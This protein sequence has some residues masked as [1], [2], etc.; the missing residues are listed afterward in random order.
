MRSFAFFLCLFVL[1]SGL[2]AQ[3]RPSTAA[4]NVQVIEKPFH[5]PGL[6]RE[7]Q[8][9]LYLP[10]GYAD[11]NKSYPVLYMHDG[12]NLFDKATAYI[13]EWGVDEVLNELYEEKGFELI[14][15]GIDNGM[16]D[17]I[18][19]LT[20]WDHEKH[21][22]AE[23]QA[24]MDFILNTVKPYIDQEYRTISDRKGT[25][26]MGGSLGG[27]ISHYAIFE[28]PEIF[29]RAGIFSPSFWWGEG[30]FNQVR[31][32]TLPEDAKMYYIV[33]AKEPP[34]MTESFEQMIELLK[35][36]GLEDQI[37]WRIDAEG[38]HNERSWNAQLREALSWL[39]SLE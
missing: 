24:Y 36:E 10:P 33:G 22:K 39:Y 12:Q 18:H 14:V 1:A 5:I 32:Q 38:G 26:I 20:A 17:R 6:N 4:S 15:V 25:A 27:L 19:E 31:E 28:Y 37:Q 3:E 35:T 23:G 13:D 21:G 11:S 34:S 16:A 7:R 29:S 8:I 2:L 30:P 9:R